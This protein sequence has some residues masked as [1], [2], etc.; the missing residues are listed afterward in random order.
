MALCGGVLLF[1]SAPKAQAASYV[2]T[3]QHSRIVTKVYAPS[4]EFKADGVVHQFRYD[5]LCANGATGCYVL[6]TFSAKVI[7]SPQGTET[8]PGMVLGH[9]YVPRACYGLA[10]ESGFHGA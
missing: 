7:A 5:I 9:Q 3:R 6:L 2:P 10:L 8:L 4:G 1:T